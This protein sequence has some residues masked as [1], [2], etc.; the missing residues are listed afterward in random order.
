MSNFPPPSVP[1]PPRSLWKPIGLTLVA[2]LLLG[3][4]T[5]AGGFA[6][7]KGLGSLLLY[8]GLMFLGLFL[9]TLF[10]AAI[11]FIVWLVQN[12]RSQ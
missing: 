11:Y 6:I 10:V 7:G 9:L 8:A 4:S 5:C 1:P 12:A 2:S 3:I